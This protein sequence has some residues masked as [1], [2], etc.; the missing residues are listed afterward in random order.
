MPTESSV[1]A[2]PVVSH[3]HTPLPWEVLDGMV[4]ASAF[5]GKTLVTMP[6]GEVRQHE[7]GM[8]ALV[9]SPGDFTLNHDANAKFIVRACNAHDE[10]L[11][12]CKLFADAAHE[13]VA[14][15]N[16]KGFACPASISFAAEQARHA[17]AKAEGR[18]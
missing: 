6:N 16:G 5:K 12:A 1:A 17:I 11:A 9:Y 13:V 4:V 14:L 7:T 2:T 8:L 15:L 18:S 10:L 3:T